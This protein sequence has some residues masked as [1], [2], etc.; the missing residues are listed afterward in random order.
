M[1]AT[2]LALAGCDG[3]LSTVDPAGPAARTIATLWWVMLVGAVLIFGLVAGLLAAAFRRGRQTRD[4]RWHERVWIVGLGLGFS[5]AI[6]A[7]LLASGLMAGERLM[8]RPAAD[9]VGVRAEARRWS[10]SFGYDA[11]PGR[12]TEDVLH[13]PAGRP[14]DVAITSAD[15][16]HSF[17]VPRLAGKLDAIPGHVNVL[18]IE[19]DHPGTYGGLTAE[20]NGE[21]YARHRFVV[22]AHD[23]AGWQAFLR[24]E[25]E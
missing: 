20:Y 14:V 21:G 17:W 2:P 5:M 10:W 3:P 4:D 19:A 12:V 15:V 13:I 9:T 6:L 1:G 16:V 8:P 18:R 7:A 22:V 11:A 23:A 24:G 25:T